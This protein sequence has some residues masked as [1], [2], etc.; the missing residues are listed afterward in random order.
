MMRQ[1]RQVNIFHRIAVEIDL[2]SVVILLGVIGVLVMSG[3][4]MYHGFTAGRQAHDAICVFTADLNARQIGSARD[5]AAT[6]E[7]LEHPTGPFADPAT[8]KLVRQGLADDKI[9]FA[10]R[11]T[12][13]ISL[14]DVTD[15]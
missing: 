8:L 15:C 3:I 4:N 2:L 5:I 13:V 12:L 1:P 11:A 6:T 10:Q 14:D 9:A 7:F